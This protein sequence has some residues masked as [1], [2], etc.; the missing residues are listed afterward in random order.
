MCKQ[1]VIIH[2]EQEIHFY[3]EEHLNNVSLLI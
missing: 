3:A 1:K 2:G